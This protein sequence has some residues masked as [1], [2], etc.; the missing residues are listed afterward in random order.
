MTRAAGAGW[1]Q[2]DAGLGDHVL[3]GVGYLIGYPTKPGYRSRPKGSEDIIDD[4][5]L[6][7]R[8]QLDRLVSACRLAVT[9]WRDVKVAADLIRNPAV[10]PSITTVVEPERPKVSGS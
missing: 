3:R 1:N 6:L 10:Q 7:S 8:G 9:D 4:L 2:T 5:L